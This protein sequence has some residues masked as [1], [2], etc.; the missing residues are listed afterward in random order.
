[1]FLIIPH[2]HHVFILTVYESLLHVAN[3]SIV[4]VIL[5]L[6]R[7]NYSLSDNVSKYCQKNTEYWTKPGVKTGLKSA[8]CV[9][10][11]YITVCV[12]VCV[13]DREG[14]TSQESLCVLSATAVTVTILRAQGFVD[15]DVDVTRVSACPLHTVVPLCMCG[16]CCRPN[17]A[18]AQCHVTLLLPSCR[19]VCVCVWGMSGTLYWCLI[20]LCGTS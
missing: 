10:Q 5:S 11:D 14:Y 17:M 16:Q 4:C 2:S 12:C 6:S 7:I 3:C 15:G 8:G 19:S 20:G 9:W 18:T 1:M 13:L